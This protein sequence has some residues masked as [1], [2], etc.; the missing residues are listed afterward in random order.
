MRKEMAYYKL[1]MEEADGE[2]FNNITHWGWFY[3]DSNYFM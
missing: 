3:P 2:R 1:L